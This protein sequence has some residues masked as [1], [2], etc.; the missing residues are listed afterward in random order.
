MKLFLLLSYVVFGFRKWLHKR[1]L[2]KWRLALQLTE[3]ILSKLTTVKASSLWD[4][5]L[6]FFSAS[7]SAYG[8]TQWPKISASALCYKFACHRKPVAIKFGYNV[9][10]SWFKER[11]LSDYKNWSWAKAVK[12]NLY[13]V[14]PFPELLSNFFSVN[15]KWNFFKH[16]PWA[17]CFLIFIRK[18]LHVFVSHNSVR[19]YWTFT[20]HIL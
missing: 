16:T 8:Y 3:F 6:V 7:R 2:W 20:F 4:N 9:H 17:V 15:W 12:P 13:Y 11:V 5:Y 19:F 10:C 18:N 1:N 14:W